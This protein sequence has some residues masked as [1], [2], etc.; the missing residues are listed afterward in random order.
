MHKYTQRTLSPDETP[1]TANLPE[2]ILPSLNYPKILHPNAVN[3]NPSIIYFYVHT[4]VPRITHAAT[5][6]VAAANRARGIMGEAEFDD[7]GNYGSAATIDVEILQAISKRVHYGSLYSV[8]VAVESQ[9]MT[10]REI[11][12]RI[13]VSSTSIGFYPTHSQ[14]KPKGARGFDHKA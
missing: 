3:V 2:P 8:W 12:L 13:Q 11:C 9:L 10:C 1:F 6:S 14:T 5:L 4:F 7:D